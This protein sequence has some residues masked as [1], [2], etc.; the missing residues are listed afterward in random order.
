MYLCFFCDQGFFFPT[1]GHWNNSKISWIHLR[2]KNQNIHDVFSN[3][4]KTSLQFLS[5]WVHLI[6]YKG[7]VLQAYY[8]YI[9]H[10]PLKHV[11]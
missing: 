11:M 9:V 2:K 4:R 5:F 6:F 3:K 1:L 7:T 8:L 10:F